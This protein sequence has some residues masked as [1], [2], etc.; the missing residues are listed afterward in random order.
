MSEAGSVPLASI[1]EVEDEEYTTSRFEQ[2]ISLL[3]KPFDLKSH[4]NLL[5]QD[6]VTSPVSGDELPITTSQDT[7]E[8][9]DTGF[10]SSSLTSSKR[11]SIV[12][13]DY[14][15][16]YHSGNYR[17]EKANEEYDDD[18][19]L[20]SETKGEDEEK[21][22]DESTTEISGSLEDLVNSFDEKVKS[23]LRNFNE[24]VSNI[25]PVQIRTQEEVIKN[26]P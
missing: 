8:F 20:L 11:S 24:N 4:L 14:A 25:A 26:R 5:P 23:C 6:S 16:Q 7:E 12:D 13:I 21:V 15:S 10:F 17:S 2:S 22:L 19:D 3:P 9:A 1:D 18:L